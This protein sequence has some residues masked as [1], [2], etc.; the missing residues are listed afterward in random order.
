MNRIQQSRHVHR[1]NKV[2]NLFESWLS[3]PEVVMALE[4]EKN[5]FSS[6]NDKT[7]TL[8]VHATIAAFFLFYMIT[9]NNINNV[10]TKN[11]LL[12]NTRLVSAVV[13]TNNRLNLTAS[14]QVKSMIEC[15]FT[16]HNGFIW[17]E[18]I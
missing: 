17:C 11:A 1:A 8:D 15:G 6:Y 9:I 2:F 3:N 14:Q 16:I 13:N 10:A 5:N 12:N 18:D 7:Y 4:N